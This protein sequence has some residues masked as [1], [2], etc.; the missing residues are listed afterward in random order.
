MET[1]DQYNLASGD[2]NL[3]T[4][5]LDDLVVTDKSDRDKVPATVVRAI[6]NFCTHNPKAW[7]YARGSTLSGTRLYGMGINEY[8]DLVK[9]EFDRRGNYHHY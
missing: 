8:F 1:P 2:L 7:I 5:E 3:L 4:L 9:K 6:Y